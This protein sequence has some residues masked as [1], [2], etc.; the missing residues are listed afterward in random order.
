[1]DI[2]RAKTNDLK[3]FGTELTHERRDNSL[4]NGKEAESQTP[5]P[6]SFPRRLVFELTNACNLRCRTCAR[7]VVDFKATVFDPGWKKF[8]DP[9]LPYVEEVTL[10]GWGEPTIH[11]DFPGFLK[12]AHDKGL[13]KYF[14]TNGLKLDE[15]FGPIFD[16]KCDIIGVSLDGAVPET[17]DSLRLGSDLKR[18]AKALRRLTQEKKRRGV[19][20]PWINLVFTAM[21]SNLREFPRLVELAAD[22]GL[23]EVKL[24]FFT[25]FDEKMAGETL[26]D[27]VPL[28]SEVFD[29][30]LRAARETGVLLKLPHLPGEDPAGAKPHKDCYTA[31][32]DFFLG[33][34]GYVRPCMSTSRKF[35]HISEA[36][37]F[38]QAWAD[39]KMVEHRRAVNSPL[40]AEGCGNCY[41]SS[42]ANW[43]LRQSFEQFAPGFAPTWG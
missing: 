19:P 6:R 33:S 35:F 11:P 31:W 16:Y 21:S 20:W 43:N 12:W 15:L 41:Q 24:V 29:E 28:V 4:L 18:V 32:R 7:N 10:M 27:H 23:E 34:D 36:A 39:P 26:I 42:F 17:N 25:A 3:D 1:M 40:T 30:A 37:D 2:L 13:R 14:C 22:L 38:S 5:I 8:F 9:A